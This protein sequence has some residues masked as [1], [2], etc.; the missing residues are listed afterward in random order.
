MS[1][2]SFQQE[3]PTES[4]PPEGTRRII[5]GCERV[6]YCGYWIKTFPAPTNTLETKKWL[7]EVL[8]RRL[9]NHIEHGLN[10]PGSR[11][12]EARKNYE[13][14]TD[15]ALQRVKAGMLAGSLFNRATDIFQN[16]VDLQEKGVEIKGSDPL[17]RECGRCL[18][19]AMELGRFVLHRSG[20]EGI[21]EL[22]GEPF[23]AFTIPIEEFYE[24]RY[25]KIGQSKR[26]ID[27]I[28]DAM[29]NTFR[30]IPSFAN[31]E[32]AIRSFAHAANTNIDTLRTDQA[33]F[34]VWP[35]LVVTAQ[36]LA[37]FIPP[38]NIAAKNDSSC[39]HSIS[40]G[41]E[42][43]LAGRDLIFFITHARAPMQKSTSEYI[44]RCRI[45]SETGE[46]PTIPPPLPA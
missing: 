43:I 4:A 15:P 13:T 14:E 27:R 28:A 19:E 16:L 36:Q 20:E 42:L 11:L 5:D 21:D 23:R 2:N 40:D 25:I 37:N 24:S 46:A 18:L 9:F 8:A 7:I 6:F 1:D 17:M 45:Y 32:P 44:E 3:M 31:I 34:D 26:D 12:D 10:I 30:P 35:Q 39:E 33:I 29:V 41:L 38:E 22:W